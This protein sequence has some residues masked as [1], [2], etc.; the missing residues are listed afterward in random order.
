M[1]EK[2]KNLLNRLRKYIKNFLLKFKR[3]EKN[4]VKKYVADFETSTWVEDET[5]VWAWAVCEIGNEE[6]I[7][8]GNDIESFIEFCKKEKNAQFYFHNLKFDGEFILYYALT[9]GF[10]HVQEKSEIED[11]TFTTLISNMGQ[12]YNI[13]LYYSKG[14]KKVHKTQFI[15]SLKIINMSVE[16]IAKTFG[17]EISKL[18]LDYNKPRE[19]RACFNR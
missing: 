19:K 13:T 8:I 9:H 7:V 18:T 14:N 12:F 16:R 6:N 10:K 4:Y 1:K 5:W 3:S 17:L 2:I 15:D 11:N